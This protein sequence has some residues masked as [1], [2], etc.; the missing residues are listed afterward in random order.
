MPLSTIMLCY[1][2][3]NEHSTNLSLSMW[4]GECDHLR[5]HNI[6]TKN[7]KDMSCDYLKPLTVPFQYNV[8]ALNKMRML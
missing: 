7:I 2:L 4:I 5:G 3:Q 1:Y 8:Y 6:N